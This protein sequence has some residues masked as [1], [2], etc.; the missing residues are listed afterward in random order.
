MDVIREILDAIGFDSVDEMDVN[1]SY[2]IEVEAFQDL[3]VEKIAEDYLSVMQYYT[4]R[5]DMMRDPEAVFDVSGE[6]WTVVEFRQDP[7][8]HRRDEDGLPEA[9][10]FVEGLWSD[11]L[12]KQGFVDAA[13]DVT[14]KAP[15]LY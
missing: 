4:Q 13:E 5:G 12:R 3:V 6:E 14:R 2:T 1:E 7:T 9:Q 11:N 8:V 15:D 10:S